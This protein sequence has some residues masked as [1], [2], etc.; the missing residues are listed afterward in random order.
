MNQVC[1]TIDDPDYEFAYE[2]TSTET[3]NKWGFATK[4]KFTEKRMIKEKEKFAKKFKMDLNLVHIE[5][6]KRK[7]IFHAEDKPSIVLFYENG[8][9]KEEKWYRLGERHRLDGAAVIEY[10]QDGSIKCKLYYIENEC[11]SEKEW[12]KEIAQLHKQLD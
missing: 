5:Q 8:Q 4:K 11:L 7:Q 9:I 3:K 1:R 12:N 6:V 2:I 10:N